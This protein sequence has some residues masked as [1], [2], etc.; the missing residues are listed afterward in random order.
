MLSRDSSSSSRDASSSL[1]IP[2]GV[3]ATAAAP[4]SSSEFPRRMQIAQRDQA[5]SNLIWHDCEADV[6]S[7]SIPKRVFFQF[8]YIPEVKQNI[9]INEAITSNVYQ[10]LSNLTGIIVPTIPRNRPTLIMN[11]F[12]AK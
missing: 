6:R 1:K 11:K 12:P 10:N 7:I 4:T 3:A 5:D 8:Q 9:R 2:S